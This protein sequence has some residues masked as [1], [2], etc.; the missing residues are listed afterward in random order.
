VVTS[1][2]PGVRQAVRLTGMG[3]VVPRGDPAALATAL[4][5]VIRNRERYLRPREKIAEVFGVDAPL[6]A[7]EALFGA[8]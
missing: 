6:A 1:N 2:L 8:L 3:E 4:V 5:R 7:Y